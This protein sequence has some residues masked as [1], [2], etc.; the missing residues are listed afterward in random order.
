M[1]CARAPLSTGRALQRPPRSAGDSLPS[2]RQEC[3][4]G[5]A[6]RRSR[7]HARQVTPSPIRDDRS[8][9]CPGRTRRRRRPGRSQRSR[10]ACH[11]HTPPTLRSLGAPTIQ[12]LVRSSRTLCLAVT[13]AL[14]MTPVASTPGNPDE[15]TVYDPPS[16]SSGAPRAKPGDLVR[17]GSAC[18]H[19]ALTWTPGHR[20]TPDVEGHLCGGQVGQERP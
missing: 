15:T 20:S 5:A 19:A 9:T 6:W 2:Q 1:P 18:H 8:G 10:A 12:I 17:H 11:R 16:L 14:T 7:S 13:L 3:P 4:F